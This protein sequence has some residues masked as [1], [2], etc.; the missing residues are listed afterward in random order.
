[1]CEALDSQS[2]FAGRLGNRE[3]AVGIINVVDRRG[4]AHRLD[5]IDGWSVM[6]I[7]RDHGVGMEGLCGGACDCASCH[8]VIDEQWISRLPAARDDELEKLDELPI[9]EPTS[10]LSCQLI[11]SE[12]LDGLAL[13][14]PNEV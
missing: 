5:A 2:R 3:A 1:M 10:R 7:L 8:V 14:L 11:W 6:E 9:L 12:H 4:V 13:V